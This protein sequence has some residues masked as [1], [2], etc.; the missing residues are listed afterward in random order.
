MQPV[1][2]GEGSGVG[3]EPPSSSGIGAS[4]EIGST[5]EESSGA[6]HLSAAGAVKVSELKKGLVCFC[7]G[8]I[9]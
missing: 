1:I 9:K 3:V 6:N 7:S 5:N 8:C 2:S 4:D